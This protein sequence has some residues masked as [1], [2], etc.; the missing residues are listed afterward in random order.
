MIVF[1]GMIQG[2]R[3]FWKKKKS[4]PN[5]IMFWEDKESG[6]L[7]IENPRIRT[8]FWWIYY[9]VLSGCPDH[10]PML[11]RLGWLLVR[12]VQMVTGWQCTFSWIRTL[13]SLCSVHWHT[14]LASASFAGSSDGL[15]KEWSSE[16][17]SN[18]FAVCFSQTKV[19]S[20]KL[21]YCPYRVF[22]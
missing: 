9:R 17:Q 20:E 2:E 4:F 11:S 10:C 8:V 7:F 18:S 14:F 13:Y 22:L 6:W 5:A 19:N 21:F 15:A 12:N 1:S 3:S 16:S